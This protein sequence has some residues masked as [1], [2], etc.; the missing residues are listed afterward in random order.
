M[1][2]VLMLC[3]RDCLIMLAQ[4]LIVMV[5]AMVPCGHQFC[6]ECLAAWLGNSNKSCPSCR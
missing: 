4:E 5:H 6:G 3:R 1:M 2:L